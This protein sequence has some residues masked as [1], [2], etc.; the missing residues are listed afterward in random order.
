MCSR[1]QSGKE[2]KDIVKQLSGNHYGVEWQITV[3]LNAS[4]MYYGLVSATPDVGK[5]LTYETKEAVD[6]DS[7][8]SFGA[9]CL[10]EAFDILGVH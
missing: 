8:V 6:V 5:P 2:D 1:S 3:I 10:V 7:A 4:G 9:Q